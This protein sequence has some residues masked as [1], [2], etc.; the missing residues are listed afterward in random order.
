MNTRQDPQALP[1]HDG[2]APVPARRMTARDA[3]LVFGPPLAVFGLR[4]FLQW[5][6]ESHPRYPTEPVPLTPAHIV[7]GWWDVLWPPALGLIAVAAL[8]MVLRAIGWG[9]IGRGLRRALP[10]LWPLLW[11]LLAGWLVQ[12]HVVAGRPLQPLPPTQATV[13]AAQPYQAS[14]RHLDGV[15]TYLTLPGYDE[16]QVALFEQADPAGL[17]TGQ[18]LTLQLA[19][20]GAGRVVVTGGWPLAAAAPAPAARA[21]A[22]AA[23]PASAPAPAA[24]SEP[25]PAPASAPAPASSPAR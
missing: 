1:E 16:P 13:V 12:R 22:S 9:R 3:A 2:A 20:N 8:W 18:V 6:A 5:R 15:R 4:A 10:W 25:V 17:Q 14:T 7:G 11:G 24:A 19:R 23:P 21:P